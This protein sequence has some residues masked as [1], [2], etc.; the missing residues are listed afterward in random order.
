MNSQISAARR[1]STLG[2]TTM[3]FSLLGGCA[4]HAPP[5]VDEAQVKIGKCRGYL[6]DERFSIT[7]TFSNR[8]IDQRSFA[9][10]WTAPVAGNSLPVIVYLPGLGESR[11]A[12][13]SWRTAWAQ[14]GYAVLSVQLLDEDQKAWSSDAARGGDFALLAHERFASQTAAARLNY[15]KLFTKNSL[16]FFE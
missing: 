3:V 13:E 16:H 12:G 4:S 9:L 7:T 6:S 10:A 11:T 14:A 5:T 2:M 15:Y 8:H 1:L